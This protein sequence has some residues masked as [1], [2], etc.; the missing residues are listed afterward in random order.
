L[1]LR[2]VAQ[3]LRN[4]G[5]TVSYQSVRRH[6]RHMD[7]ESKIERLERKVEKWKKCK[8]TDSETLE[9]LQRQR[10]QLRKWIHAEPNPPREALDAKAKLDG[11][12]KLIEKLIT[13]QKLLK[14]L[15]R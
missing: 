12:I 15:L 9:E 11:E 5:I 4:H 13:L 14:K 6:K 1:S 3:K 10:E 7:L 8:P 2:K